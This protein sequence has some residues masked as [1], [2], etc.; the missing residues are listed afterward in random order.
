MTGL[1]YIANISSSEAKYFVN[2]TPI[3][4]PARKMN[5]ATYA[6]HFVLVGR[7]RY[8]DPSGS[9]ALGDN[10]FC[11]SFVDSIPPETGELNCIVTIPPDISINDDLILYV[12][13]NSAALLTSRGEVITICAI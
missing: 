12:F 2:S 7:S 5:P 1:V 4:M 11:A 3:V 8:P 9:F 10:P 13:R 6:P